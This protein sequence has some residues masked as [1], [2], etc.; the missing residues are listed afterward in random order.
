MEYNSQKESAIETLGITGIVGSI[1]CLIQQ[2]LFIQY[3]YAWIPFSLFVL[4]AFVFV[5]FLL[6][7]KMKSSSI[8]LV[9]VSAVVLFLEQLF[10]LLI[11]GFLLLTF[12][13]MLF[14][15]IAIV[16]IYMQE[17]HRYIADV[18]K[19]SKADILSEHY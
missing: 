1:A 2:T 5:S 13:M 17:L 6:F 12:L 10:F 11:G 3:V 16:L 8:K 19:D 7:F 18:E 14:S 4:D 15:I 9:I